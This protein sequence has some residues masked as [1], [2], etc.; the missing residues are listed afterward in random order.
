M[1]KSLKGINRV[2]KKIRKWSDHFSRQNFIPDAYLHVLWNF[3]F[4]VFFIMSFFKVKIPEKSSVFHCL[5]LFQPRRSR[6]YHMI[7]Y[8]VI[9][10]HMISYD[11]IWYHMIAAA[12]PRLRPMKRMENRTFFGNFDFEKWHYQKKWKK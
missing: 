5:N 7:S 3:S 4:Y 6:G 12:S 8:D 2:E 11:V 9:W 1:L 10:Y